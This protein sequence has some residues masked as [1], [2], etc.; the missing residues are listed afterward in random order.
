MRWEGAE[1]GE[2]K[3]GEIRDGFVAYPGSIGS[4]IRVG[5]EL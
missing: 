4:E 3:D 1:G 2:E 5:C